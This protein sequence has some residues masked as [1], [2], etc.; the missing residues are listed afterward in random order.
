MKPGVSTKHQ[1]RDPEA[2]AGVDEAGALLGGGDVDDAAEVARLVCDDA[3]RPAAEAG[4]ARDHVARPARRDLEQVAAVDHVAHDVAHVIDLTRER[5]DV[6]ARID[7]AAG[8]APR[9]HGAAAGVAEVA[10]Q[11]A[12]DLD[13]GVVVVGDEVADAVAVVHGGPAE[14]LGGD[15]LADGL[16][17]HLRAR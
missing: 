11:V 9:G 3:D 4:E 6:A 8:Q 5:R 14:G 1:Q 15:L 10:E 16:L 7:P 2:L 17:D 13:G 12:H